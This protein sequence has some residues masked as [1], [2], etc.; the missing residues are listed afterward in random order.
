MVSGR[1]QLA[2]AF[3]FAQLVQ[4]L[5]GGIPRHSRRDEP[6]A[7]YGKTLISQSEYPNGVARLV[8]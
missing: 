6:C 8:P 4:R 5:Q 3:L 7:A 2:R 1:E